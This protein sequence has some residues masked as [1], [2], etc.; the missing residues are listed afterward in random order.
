MAT[1]QVSKMVGFR[2]D[3]QAQPDESY[4]K[5]SLYFSSI[6]QRYIRITEF[7]CCHAHLLKRHGTNYQE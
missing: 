6:S 2:T 7:I 3:Y 1:Q 4:K 5:L